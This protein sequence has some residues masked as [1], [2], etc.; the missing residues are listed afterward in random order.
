LLVGWL[1]VEGAAGALDA[2]VTV[3]A[4]VGLAPGVFVGAAV[5]VAAAA[6]TLL[7]AP[8]ELSEPAAP[9]GHQTTR[10]ADNASSAA[11]TMR[12]RF[13]LVALTTSS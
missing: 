10:H 13:V 9:C 5:A 6:A 3:G 11:T 8:G 7:D 4:L 2:M 12:A 1:L